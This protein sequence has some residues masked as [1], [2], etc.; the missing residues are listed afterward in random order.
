MELDPAR[1]VR[2]I[3]KSFCRCVGDKRK[4]RKNVGP[5]WKEAKRPGYPRHGE[6]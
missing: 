6:G 3:K 5:L 1:D 4:V 2:G